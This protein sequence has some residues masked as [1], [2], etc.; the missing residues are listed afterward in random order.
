M[1]LLKSFQKV[2]GLSAALLLCSASA[3]AA[4]TW[5]FNAPSHGAV[6]GNTMTV[7]P[8]GNTATVTAWKQASGSGNS[9]FGQTRLSEWGGNLGAGFETPSPGHAL[10]NN[11]ADEFILLEFQ[12]PT[13]LTDLKIGY[14]NTD[15]DMTVMAYT[16]LGTPDMTSV[17]SSGAT[18][19]LNNGWVN[20]GNPLNVQLNT[21][22]NI[23]AGNESSN[24]WLIGA[25]NR[26][27][28]PANAD[29]GSH[30]DDYVK[31]SGVKGHSDNGVPVPATLALFGIGL[32]ALGRKKLVG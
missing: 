18:G 30:W 21:F 6:P 29:G 13:T 3:Q 5:T 8:A 2:I 28:A 10:D 4:V 19:L 12:K 20:T 15:S 9:L 22:T 32:L 17:S 1:T 7:G 27:I 11:G 24:Y 31:L 26:F 25:Y 23:N 14:R 16:G